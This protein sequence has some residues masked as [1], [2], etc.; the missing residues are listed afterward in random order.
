MVTL[1]Q[2][3]NVIRNLQRDKVVRL[4]QRTFVAWELALG[5]GTVIRV[6][7]DSADVIVGHVPPPGGDGI[8][9]LDCDFHLV[10]SGVDDVVACV[11]RGG[12]VGWDGKQTAYRQAV[13]E[14]ARPRQ[15]K[16]YPGTAWHAGPLGRPTFGGSWHS[17]KA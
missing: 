14:A 5:A 3:C 4:T 9:L 10:W 8:P 15:L 11:S 1:A 17:A 2:Y 7:A 6:A 13:K 16:L 12:R